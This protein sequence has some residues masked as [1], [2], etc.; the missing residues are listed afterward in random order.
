MQAASNSA[1]S[2]DTG[3]VL[4]DMLKLLKRDRNHSFKKPEPVNKCK[5]GFNHEDIAQ[6]LI[7]IDD[8]QKFDADP[9]TYRLPPF[10]WMSLILFF[11][12]TWKQSR[13]GRSVTSGGAYRFFYLMRISSSRII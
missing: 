6:F 4:P 10:L 3:K 1:C 9:A 7:S 11:V 8:K 13:M 5:F 2:D 12:D